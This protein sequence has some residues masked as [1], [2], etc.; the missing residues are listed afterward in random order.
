MSNQTVEAIL[1]RFPE[2]VSAVNGVR[3][4]DVLVSSVE[5]PLM[6]AHEGNLAQLN[7][8]NNNQLNE[9]FVI[10]NAHRVEK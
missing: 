1:K 7:S 2:A 3:V 4:G 8:L 10:G 9:L 5:L 6:I